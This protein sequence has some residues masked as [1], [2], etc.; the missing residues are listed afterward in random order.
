MEKAKRLFEIATSISR[1]TQDFFAV[2]GPGKGD[3]A[4]ALFMKLLREDATEI[5]FVDHAEQKISG[6]NGLAVDFYFRDEA[7]I[8]EIALTLR[9]A[10]TEYEKDILK[11]VLAIDADNPVKHLVFISKPGAVKRRSEPAPRAMANW[12]ERV[13]GVKTHIWELTPI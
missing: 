4:T 11:T 6:D 12:L 13:H 1:D 7:T 8:V 5:F 3:H 2:K 9:N 10:S